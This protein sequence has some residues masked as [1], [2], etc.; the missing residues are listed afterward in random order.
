MQSLMEI[1]GRELLAQI[2]RIFD[3]FPEISAI[4][5]QTLPD[6]GLHLL[7]RCELTD[8]QDD[9]TYWNGVVSVLLSHHL[10]PWMARSSLITHCYR[11]DE[12]IIQPYSNRAVRAA[13][14]AGHRAG[15]EH[16][17]IATMSARTF[18]AME[19]QRS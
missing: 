3:A 2:G 15:A 17:H 10:K 4:M 18:A 13:I 11:W 5:P 12:E 19:V 9:P 1:E 8:R 14:M 7:T 6:H 16:A